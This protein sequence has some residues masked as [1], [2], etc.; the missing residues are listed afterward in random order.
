[1]KF[2]VECLPNSAGVALSTEQLFATVR[3]EFAS[4]GATVE[5]AV[6]DVQPAQFEAD[7]PF[8]ARSGCDYVVVAEIPNLTSLVD[9]ASNTGRA[10]TMVAASA[11]SSSDSGAVTLTHWLFLSH[12]GYCEREG[13]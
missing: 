13:R 2:M 3:P 10:V 4:V 1:M 8:E 6:L 5:L 9:F 11:W 12:D 7:S